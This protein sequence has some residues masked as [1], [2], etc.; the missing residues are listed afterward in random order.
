MNTQHKRSKTI[1]KHYLSVFRKGFSCQSVL[2]AISEEWRSALGRGDHVAAFFMDLS[3]A[4]DC[5][6]YTLVTA[7]LTAYGLSKNA[8]NLSSSYLSD[9]RQCVQIGNCRSTFQYLVKGAPQGSILG[10]LLFNIFLM[11]SFILLKK[12]NFLIM[13]MIIPCP[14]PTRSR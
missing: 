11:T 6:T 14:A 7:K 13:L 8:V 9:R 1:F 5:L 2:L 4:F 12:V 10:P 3:K